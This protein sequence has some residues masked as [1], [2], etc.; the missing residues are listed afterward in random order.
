MKKK[1]DRKRIVIV[2]VIIASVLISIFPAIII[3]GQIWPDGAY[4]RLLCDTDHQVLLETCR[5]ILEKGDLKVGNRYFDMSKFPKVIRELNPT[6][7]W[8]SNDNFLCIGIRAGMSHIGVYA[9]PE[10]FKAPYEKFKYGDKQIIPGL[11]YFD[12]DYQFKPEYDRKI[13]KLLHKGRRDI[14][15]S[16]T[17]AQ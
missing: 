15:K 9:Y 16:K 5:E 8:L 4:E 10:D 17:P 6:V 7:V 1:I 2:V 11:W 14:E 12:E 13:E 3:V